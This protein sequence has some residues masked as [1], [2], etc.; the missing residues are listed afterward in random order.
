MTPITPGSSPLMRQEV[1]VSTLF[2]IALAVVAPVA[3][4]SYLSPAPLGFTI[5]IQTNWGAQPRWNYLDGA[6]EYRV[7]YRAV[8]DTA[9]SAVTSK[10]NWLLVAKLIPDVTYEFRLSLNPPKDG[11]RAAEVGG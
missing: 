8:G 9:W 2:V 1:V 4:A 7:E 10:R 11:V 5:K 3:S 6:V